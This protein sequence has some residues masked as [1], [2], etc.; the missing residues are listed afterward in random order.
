MSIVTGITYY[1]LTF[2]EKG[3]GE[4]SEGY[5]YMISLLSSLSYYS[6]VPC[7]DIKRTCLNRL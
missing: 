6:D 7:V 3:D 5:H 4:D 1:E 2:K